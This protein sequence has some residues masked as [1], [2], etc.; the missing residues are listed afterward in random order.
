M[1]ANLNEATEYTVTCINRLAPDEK[2]DK[3]EVDLLLFSALLANIKDAPM[4]DNIQAQ[5][6]SMIN[7][8]DALEALLSQYIP[9]YYTA[10]DSAVVEVIAPF[11]IEVTS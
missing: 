2:I 3:E 10:L 11:V 7:D 5:F 9:N 4:P 8:S 6:A 1:F